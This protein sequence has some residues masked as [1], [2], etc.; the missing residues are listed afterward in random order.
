MHKNLLNFYMYGF[1]SY[2]NKDLKKWLEQELL[3]YSL[4]KEK[5][6]VSLRKNWPKQFGVWVVKNNL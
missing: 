1:F 3:F 2:S 6:V 5:E 4:L